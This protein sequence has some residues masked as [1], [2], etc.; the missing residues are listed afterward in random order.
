MQL[1]ALVRRLVSFERAVDALDAA[2]EPF[3]T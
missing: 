1:N 2:T 3:G